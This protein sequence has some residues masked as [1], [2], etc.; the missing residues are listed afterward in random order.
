VVHNRPGAVICFDQFDFR[1]ADIERV[2]QKTREAHSQIFLFLAGCDR[3]IA[4]SLTG[5][6]IARAELKLP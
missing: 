5:A 6:A 2:S 3:A 1:E 4:T